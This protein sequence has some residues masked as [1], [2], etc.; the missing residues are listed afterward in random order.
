MNIAVLCSG[1]G[2][3]LQ[4][5][6]DKIRSGYIPA[7]LVLVVSDKADALA[8]ER[9]KKAGIDTL[10]VDKKNFKSREELDN[11]IKELEEK[12]KAK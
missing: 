10:V 8:L 7:K 1:S 4:A 6:I 11:K 3:N 2:T 12:L 9:A 5:I